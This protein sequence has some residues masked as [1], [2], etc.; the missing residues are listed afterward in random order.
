MTL[1]QCATIVPFANPETRVPI[2]VHWTFCRPSIPAALRM[3]TLDYVFD[4][5]AHWGRP[6][7]SQCDLSMRE[8]RW[9]MNQNTQPNGRL[10]SRRILTRARILLPR[11]QEPVEFRD[12]KQQVSRCAIWFEQTALNKAKQGRLRNSAKVLARRPRL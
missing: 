7:H 12:R 9:S 3:K 1:D 6:S 10:T 5:R 2:I 8:M 4:R 11:A